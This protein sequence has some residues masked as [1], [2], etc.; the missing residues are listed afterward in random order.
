MLVRDL[1]DAVEKAKILFLSKNDGNLLQDFIWQC[2]KIDGGNAALPN[3]PTDK[4]TAQEHGNQALQGLRTLGTLILSNGQ[5]RKLL[6]D[7]TVLLRDIAGDAASNAAGKIN[8]SEE[9]LNRLDEAA[10]D[11][12]WHEVPSVDDLKNQAKDTYGKNKPFSRS[13]I[14]EEVNKQKD[15]SDSASEGIMNAAKNLTETAKSNVDDDTQQKAKD[16]ANSAKV[17]TKQYFQKKMPQER[18]EQTIWRLKKMVVEIQRH[19]DCEFP[20]FSTFLTQY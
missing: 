15:N 5:F 14:K 12:T 8:P 17:Q 10:P 11:D 6:S 2:Q 1:R 7:A 18:R 20:M 9:R 3:A 16:A 19:P 13:D 4:A